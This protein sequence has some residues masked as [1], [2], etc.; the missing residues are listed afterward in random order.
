MFLFALASKAWK[1]K[2]VGLRKCMPKNASEPVH[3][4]GNGKIV[5]TPSAR[6]GMAATRFHT[7]PFQSGFPVTS[8]RSVKASIAY[9]PCLP[10]RPAYCGLVAAH[11]QCQRG[12]GFGPLFHLTANV[13]GFGWHYMSFYRKLRELG[14]NIRIKPKMRLVR[15]KA[16][17]LIV[18]DPRVARDIATCR[19][20][21]TLR[22]LVGAGAG[23]SGYYHV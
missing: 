19:P 4:R 16:E 6:K 12:W 8:L 14:L 13:R 9:N 11:H 2:Y 23:G 17:V 15:E 20:G 5:V 10:M 18:H 1:R 22:G 21:R 3:R 7:F